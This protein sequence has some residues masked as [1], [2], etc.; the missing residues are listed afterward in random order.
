[1]RKYLTDNQFDYINLIKYDCQEMAAFHHLKTGSTVD[2]MHIAKSSAKHTQE[3]RD[4]LSTT[5]LVR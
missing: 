2:V 5:Y 1:M 4:G 3:R